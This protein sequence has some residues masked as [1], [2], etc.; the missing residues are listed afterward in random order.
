MTLTNDRVNDRIVN[1]EH[2]QIQ[3]RRV[4]NVVDTMIMSS[5]RIT[6]ELYAVIAIAIRLFNSDRCVNPSAY[7]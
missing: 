7:E 5:M 4:E 1:D 3:Q 2:S 6:V